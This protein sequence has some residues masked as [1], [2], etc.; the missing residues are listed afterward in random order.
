MLDK[1]SQ[2]G[3]PIANLQNELNPLVNQTEVLLQGKALGAF[4]TASRP[5][6]KGKIIENPVICSIA[7]KYQ[8]TPAQVAL[9]WAIDKGNVAVIPNSRSKARMIENLQIFDIRLDVEDTRRIDGLNPLCIG[10]I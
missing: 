4:F 9:K 3:I 10:P 7:E 1:V 6:A 5:L 8:K 2:F